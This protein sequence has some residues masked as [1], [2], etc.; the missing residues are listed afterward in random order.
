MFIDALPEKVYAA[1]VE[2]QW[3][4]QSK[5]RLIEARQ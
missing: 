5:V 2:P 3:L 4:P 1:F